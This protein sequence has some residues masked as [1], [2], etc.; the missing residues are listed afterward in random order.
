MFHNN[1]RGLLTNFVGLQELFDRHKNIDIMTPETHVIDEQ[2][3]DNENLYKIPGYKFIK[4]NPKAGR[5][6]G[7]YAMF[8]RESVKWVR[9]QALEKHNIK[10]FGLNL[11][12]F[13]KNSKRFLLAAY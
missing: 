4:C 7:V 6:G 1:I 13:N 10:I 12:Y 11:N 2:Y 8:I 9:R 5:G 3:D